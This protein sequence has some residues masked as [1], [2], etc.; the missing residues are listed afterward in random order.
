M[1]NREADIASLNTWISG[2]MKRG[3]IAVLT[4]RNGDMD[5]VGS[6]TAMARLLGP[7]A[8]ACGVHMGT[9]ARA[10]LADVGAEFMVLD[11][12][13]PAWPRNLGGVIVVDAAGPTQPGIELP[14]APL[15]IIDHHAAGAAFE[16][17]EGDISLIWDTASTAQIIQAWA[18][19]SCPD[20]LDVDTRRL[21]LAGIVADTG[22]F[23]HGGAAPL[24]DAARLCEGVDLDFSQFVESMES[25]T[26]NHSQK[27]AI[28]KALSRVESIEAG[29]WFL[30]RTRAST[31]EGTVA[32]ALISAGADVALV[33]RKLQGETRLTARAG[34]TATRAGVHLGKLMQAMVER[35]GG[36]G[37]GHDGAA[38]WTGPID[39]I[40]ATSGFIA[41]LSATRRSE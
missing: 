36:E 15:C 33:S 7:S 14:D 25:V 27:V 35:S 8:R 26:L 37:G 1:T 10:T 5:T 41:L 40:D 34:R 22:R 39:P 16:L 6:A 31:N 4:H 28:A 24:A 11:A 19:S 32:R 23:R 17:G 21:L 3:A 13:R 38:G 18:E 2:A 20:R 29:H 12:Q 9:L 30:L